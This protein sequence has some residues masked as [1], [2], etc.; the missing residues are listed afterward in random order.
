MLLE[1][2]LRRLHLK[3]VVRRR[4][5]DL[6][7]LRP[8]QIFCLKPFIPVGGR[9]ALFAQHWRSLQTDLFVRDVVIAGHSIP[10]VQDPPLSQVKFTPLVG[11]YKQ[12]LKEEI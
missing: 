4:V 6:L 3:D 5:F 2:I 1:M 9:L 8:L 7:S 12:V 10:F 11:E